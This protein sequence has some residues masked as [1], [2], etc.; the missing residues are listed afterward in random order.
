MITPV[1]APC[2]LIINQSD[3]AWPGTLTPSLTFQN[4]FLKPIMEFEAFF[5]T[6]TCMAVFYN[7]HYTLLHQSESEV[8]QSCLTLCDPMDC[9]LPGSSIHGI[10]QARIL[11]WVAISFSRG[12]SWPRDWTQISCITGRFFTF[13]ATGRAQENKVYTVSIVSPPIC[14]EWWDWMPWS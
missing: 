1:T 3:C 5:S 4:A 9:R 2:Y 12:S 14:H 8:S 7:K 13:W 11:K 6:T 10:F